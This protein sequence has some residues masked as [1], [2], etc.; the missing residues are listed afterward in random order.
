MELNDKKMELNLDI[1]KLESRSSNERM[2]TV[3][4]L[5]KA[6][7]KNFGFNPM[8]SDAEREKAIKK[9]KKLLR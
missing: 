4:R 5:R 9:W 1:L 3:L 2:R 7:G 6:T 8:G